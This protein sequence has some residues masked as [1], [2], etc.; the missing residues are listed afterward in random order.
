MYIEYV[1]SPRIC[2]GAH[3]SEKVSAF[4]TGVLHAHT[5]LFSP[6]I[7]GNPRVSNDEMIRRRSGRVARGMSAATRRFGSPSPRGG[8]RKMD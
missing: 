7:S 3:G 8:P 5:H 6:I 4:S 2:S 1:S